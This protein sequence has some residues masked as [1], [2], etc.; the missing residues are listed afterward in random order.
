M[1]HA[2]NRPC[3]DEVLYSSLP[4]FCLHLNLENMPISAQRENQRG[5]HLRHH[6]QSFVSPA[7]CIVQYDLWSI[8]DSCQGLEHGPPMI[9]FN[10]PSKKLTLWIVAPPSPS[11]RGL[12]V[13]QSQAGPGQVR[14]TLLCVIYIRNCFSDCKNGSARCVHFEGLWSC[15]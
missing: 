6:N 2:C 10:D 14:A 7:R 1:H 9:L 13:S 5:D 11:L 15:Q 4:A 3:H 8:V 12:H